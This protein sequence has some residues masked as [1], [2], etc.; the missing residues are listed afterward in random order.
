MAKQTKTSRSPVK[1]GAKKP[2]FTEA[3]LNNARDSIRKK[4]RGVTRDKLDEIASKNGVDI[5]RYQ[6]LG[7][8]LQVMNITNS[9]IGAIMRKVYKGEIKLSEVA[10]QAQ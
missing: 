7:A 10:K 5:N 1:K 6:H 9:I 3:Q 8:G 4:L 2:T